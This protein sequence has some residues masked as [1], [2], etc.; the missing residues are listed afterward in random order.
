MVPFFSRMLPCEQPHSLSNIQVRSIP[1]LNFSGDHLRSTI[2]CGLGI[3]WGYYNTYCFVNWT[4]HP[5]RTG[6]AHSYF[7][8][9]DV[10]V[11]CQYTIQMPP[12][13][14]NSGPFQWFSDSAFVSCKKRNH[15]FISYESR[16]PIPV[17]RLLF[18][19]FFQ[20]LTSTEPL[21]YHQ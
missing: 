4:F 16:Q 8:S 11:V 15:L 18:F 10:W 12:F 14:F 5:E 2:I 3:I 7:L 19:D 20:N 17:I 9:Q 13:T 1:F 6:C 21:C